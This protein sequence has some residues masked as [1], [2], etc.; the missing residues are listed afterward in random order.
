MAGIIPTTKVKIAPATDRIKKELNIVSKVPVV[1]AGCMAEIVFRSPR[2]TLQSMAYPIMY[3][4]TGINP[5][6]SNMTKVIEE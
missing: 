6:S 3:K 1:P 2:K 4:M 5:R